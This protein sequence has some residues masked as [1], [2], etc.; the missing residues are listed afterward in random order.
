MKKISSILVVLV[1]FNFIFSSF[2]FAENNTTIQYSEES[3]NELV[4]SGTVSIDGE[5]E[6]V[7]DTKSST[8]SAVGTQTSFMA[9]FFLAATTL[10][11]VFANEG[12][13]YYTDSDYSASEIGWF[14]VNSLV[15]GEYL[16]FNSNINQTNKELNPDI[17]PT[18]ISNAMDSLKDLVV[19]WFQIL[20]Y[21]SIALIIILLIFTGLR[22][23]VSDMAEDRARYK[24]VLKAWF[25]G[26]LFIGTLPYIISI[27]NTIYELL[28]DIFWNARVSL[29][30]AGYSS[31]ESGLFLECLNGTAETG[32]LTS[33]A[34]FIEFAAFVIIDYIFA[35][36]YLMRLFRIFMLVVLS[37]VYGIL[38]IFDV[39]KGG[40][41]HIGEWLT[42]YSINIFIQPLHALLY[43]TFMFAV[44]N[45]VISAP[46]LA[47]LFLWLLFRAEKIFYIILDIDMKQAT[48]IFAK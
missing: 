44:S 2:V 45:I 31:F 42:K 20:R 16:L 8:A 15:F 9:G 18:G 47:I 35:G 14:S 17:E 22:L 24:K 36:K 4:D 1:L 29:E 28:M 25:V 41:G 26:L 13:F 5:K 39:I 30:E 34:Y 7:T 32:G 43:L 48:S 33:A 12:G 27:I 11:R 38:H 46:L 10:L 23:A 19:T 21:F 3:F 40:D 6:Q 37:P